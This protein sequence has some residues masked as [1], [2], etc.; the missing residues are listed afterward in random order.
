VRIVFFGSPAFAIPS[1]TALTEAGHEIALVVSQPAKPVGRRAE[2]TDP[3]VAHL[4]REKGLALF[5]PHSLKPDEAVA[6]LEEAHAD[7]FVVAAYGKLLSP[8][9]LGLPR[10]FPVN[11]HGSILPRWR[12]ASPVQAAIL[13]GDATTGVSIMRMEAGM[14]TGPIFAVRDTVIGEAETGGELGD[15]LAE[16]GAALLV[17]TLARLPLDPLPQ[18]DTQATYCPR[19]SREDGLVDW[20]LSAV[21]LSRRDRAFTPWPGLY[22][23]RKGARVKLS[24][25]S[26]VAAGRP[27]AAPGTVLSVSPAL[28]VACGEGAVAVRTLQAEGRKAVPAADFVRGERIAAGDTWSS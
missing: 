6:R 25:L 17:E 10:L 28:A 14:D 21:E 18:D 16:M 1:V 20:A 13:A 27:G 22:T 24:G 3:P 8:R 26:P 9:V 4:A 19:I 5:Q 11:V 7:L 15:R 12:G 23:F 2:P